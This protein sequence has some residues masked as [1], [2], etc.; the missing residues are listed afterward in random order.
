M[1][2]KEKAILIRLLKE[3]GLIDPSTLKKLLD[4]IF[5]ETLNSSEDLKIKDLPLSFAFMRNFWGDDEDDE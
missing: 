1:N 2:E 4:C 5:E 3:E